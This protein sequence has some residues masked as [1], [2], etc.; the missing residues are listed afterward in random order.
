MDVVGLDPPLYEH[1]SSIFIVDFDN[2]P[3]G[4]YFV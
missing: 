1:F 2:C 4:I 3:Q